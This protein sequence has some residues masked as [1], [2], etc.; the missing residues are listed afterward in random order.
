MHAPDLAE[1]VAGLGE[2]LRFMGICP[3]EIGNWQSLRSPGVSMHLSNGLCTTHS[4]HD[5]LYNSASTEL[6]V[7]HLVELVTLIGFYIMIAVLFLGFEADL[8]EGAA[9]PF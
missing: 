7:A 9:Q 3:T 4:I 6:G 2:R 8:P 5:D 1:K